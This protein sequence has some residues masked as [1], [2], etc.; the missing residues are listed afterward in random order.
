MVEV[1]GDG[2]PLWVVECAGFELQLG[3]IC[4]RRAMIVLQR[5]GVPTNLLVKLA[6][7]LNLIIRHAG[8]LQESQVFCM[9]QTRRAMTVK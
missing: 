3:F 4:E 6:H 5:I 7:E 1:F 8:A 2:V 9:F